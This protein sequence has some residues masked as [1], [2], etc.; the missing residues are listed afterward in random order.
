M[1]QV[2]FAFVKMQSLKEISCFLV[3]GPFSRLL[4]QTRGFL[5]EQNGHVISSW[6]VSRCHI[7]PCVIIPMRQSKQMNKYCLYGARQRATDGQ[8]TVMVQPW[9]YLCLVLVCLILD[10]FCFLQLISIIPNLLTFIKSPQKRF[11]TCPGLCVSLELVP[12]AS[13]LSS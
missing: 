1:F 3:L 2:I 6:A 5:F 10:P 7:S 13:V 11:R 8:F 12:T 4:Q 9:F